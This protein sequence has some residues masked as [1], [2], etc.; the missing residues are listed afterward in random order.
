[1]ISIEIVK[2]LAEEALTRDD[3]FLV[4]VK[5]T[6]ANQISVLVESDDVLTI[7]DCVSISRYIEGNLDRE[8]EDF[9]LSVSSPGLSNPM[10]VPRQYKKNIGRNLEIFLHDNPKKTNGKLLEVSEDS[11]KIEITE[12]RKIEGKKR[13]QEVIE[14]MLINYSDI[15]SAKVEI[16]FK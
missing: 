9:E 3:L 1:M 11:I 14:E 7:D 6:P 15:K 8:E 12:M 5:L 2:K 10:Q 16:S 13:K 4:D